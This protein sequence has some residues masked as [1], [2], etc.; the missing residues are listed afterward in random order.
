M[1][2]ETV[3]AKKVEG[4]AGL[5]AARLP[6]WAKALIAQQ[7]ESSFPASASHHIHHGSKFCPES[8]AKIQTSQGGN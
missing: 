5:S 4:K 2:N 1:K 8:S 7:I 3:G 6:W